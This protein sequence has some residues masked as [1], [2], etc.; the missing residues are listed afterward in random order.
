[1]TQSECDGLR[2]FS[3]RHTR[4][5]SSRVCDHLGHP[6]GDAKTIVFPD[7]EMLVKLEE[8]V[9]GRDCF[10]IVSTCEPVNEN[11]V[12]L[13]IFTDCL[14]RA[15]ARRVTLVIPY[16]GYGRQ[17]RKDEGRVPITAKLVANLITAAR[18]DRV[19]TIDLHAAQIQGFF[20]LPVDHLSATPVF[21]EYF[22]KMRKDLGELCLVSPDVGNVKV[23]EGLANLLGGDLAIIN[24][25]RLSGSE[26]AVGNLI[27]TVKGKAVLMFDD[28]IS[29]AGT[30][31]EAARLVKEHG[32]REVIAA[33]THPVLVGMAMQRLAE[34]PIS[35]LVVTDTIPAG[36]RVEPLK[37]KIVQLSVGPMLGE[38]IR[39]IHQNQSISA[40]F[41]RTAGMKR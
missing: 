9:R 19:L 8:D 38:A 28:M 33:C 26:V 30:V 21:L 10:V 4:E 15:S 12:E 7:G 35:R 18:A 25:R 31:C 14:K 40:L 36:P 13:L 24:K 39:R 1:M 37:D 5:L 3:G 23:A 20:D 34:A 32:A 6:L 27:G 17:D 22:E 41:S 2:I 16:F 11:L 29:T